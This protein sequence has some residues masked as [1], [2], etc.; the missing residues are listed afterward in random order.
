M[1]LHSPPFPSPKKGEV[2]DE[3][4]IQRDGERACVVGASARD[5]KKKNNPKSKV[6]DGKEKR[7][8]ERGWGRTDHRPNDIVNDLQIE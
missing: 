1:Q 4:G 8:G 2:R 5:Q 3:G 6:H 7:S